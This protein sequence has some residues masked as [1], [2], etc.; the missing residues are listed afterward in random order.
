MT[1]A[2]PESHLLAAVYLFER[3]NGRTLD[4]GEAWELIE[5]EMNSSRPEEVAA[6]ICQTIESSPAP[7][8]QYRGT[9]FWVL[10]KRMDP[11]LL[12]FFRRHL[13]LEVEQDMEVAYQI[14]I[15]L[16]NLDEP[17][18]PSRQGGVSVIDHTVNHA[19]ARRYIERFGC[20]R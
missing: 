1:P 19:A 11:E 4:S 13:T 20:Q 8:A 2:F 5:A 17:V 3:E 7:N 12:D 16:D 14:M 6:W 18:W 10:G 15:A 9:A